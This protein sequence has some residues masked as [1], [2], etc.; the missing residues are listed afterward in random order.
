MLISDWLAFLSSDAAY[1]LS[2]SCC[3]SISSSTAGCGSRSG[4]S[5]CY[6]C[7]AYLLLRFRYLLVFTWIRSNS[8]IKVIRMTLSRRLESQVPDFFSKVEIWRTLNL[9]WEGLWVKY[10][11]IVPYSYAMAFLAVRHPIHMESMSSW[12]WLCSMTLTIDSLYFPQISVTFTITIVVCVMW[13]LL[14]NLRVRI[15][16]KIG[17]SIL[18]N[19]HLFLYRLLVW[20]RFGLNMIAIE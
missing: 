12:E 3:Q 17:A 6:T 16:S 15:S 18:S 19:Q 9:W 10:M 20:I 4:C 7:L 5:H 13:Y 1:I 2:A 11:S 8:S 14:I